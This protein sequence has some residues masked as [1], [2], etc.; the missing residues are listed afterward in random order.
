VEAFG[1]RLLDRLELRGDET[2][3]DAGCGAGGVTLLLAERLPGGR[4][5]GAD[6]SPSM[7]DRAREVLGDAADL[8]VADLLELELD[9]PVDAIFSSATFHWILDH[10]RLYERLF[11]ALRPGGRLLAQC[12]GKGNVAAVV[13]AIA[14][15]H[16][17]PPFGEHLASMPHPWRF[18]SPGETVAALER[19]GFVDAKAELHHEVVRPKEPHEYLATMI[20]GAH[21]EHL[22]RDLRD[23]FVARV[24]AELGEP[25]TVHYVRLTMSA[26]RPA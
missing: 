2:V 15:A 18:A 4:V 17:E 12:G 5:I 11:A 3:L 13:A 22:P 8:R 10:D 25:V 6:A 7:I 26:R 9:A 1:Q 21:L 24:L 23:R 19:A 20:L 14:A 16:G